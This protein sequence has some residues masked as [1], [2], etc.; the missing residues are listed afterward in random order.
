MY[1]R[2]GETRS[3]ISAKGPST[4]N[5][6]QG[7]FVWT[8][9]HLITVSGKLWWY[10]VLLSGLIAKI[11]CSSKQKFV[12]GSV[13]MI[14]YWLTAVVPVN[15]TWQIVFLMISWKL[16]SCQ[17]FVIPDWLGNFAWN[18]SS[19]D[20]TENADYVSRYWTALKIGWWY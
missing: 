19:T 4:V 14:F 6:I 15:P 18:N 16:C 8:G 13:L 10:I 3:I 2:L 5:R 20:D 9:K 12:S 11:F 17:I 1:L 7:I